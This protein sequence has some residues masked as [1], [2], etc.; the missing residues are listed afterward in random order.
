MRVLIA[1][2]E[3]LARAL[4]R[5]LLEDLSGV[6]VAGEASDGEEAIALARSLAPDLVFLDIDMPQLSG[7][8]AAP[9]LIDTGVEV[10]FVTAHEEHAIDAFEVGAL[11]YILKPVSRPRLAHT[12]ERAQRRRAAR[13]APTGTPTTAPGE[14]GIWVPVR[15]GV[16]RVAFADVQRVEAAR[17][18]VYFHTAERAYLHR[19]TMSETAALLA[20][21]GLL[22]VH[23]SAFIRPERVVALRRHGKS[24]ALT[25]D[26]GASVPVG[27]TYR[28]ATLTAIRPA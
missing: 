6:A 27:T 22:R 16:A 2:D 9:T 17:D 26:D 10:I 28:V 24:L 4:L 19:I 8:H 25:L 7:I 20:G 15:H 13:D 18:H 1:D 21:T 5:A 12:V 23:R 11:D 14:D 3:P